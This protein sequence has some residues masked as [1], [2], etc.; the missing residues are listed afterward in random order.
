MFNIDTGPSLPK[1]IKNPNSSFDHVPKDDVIP[2]DNPTV[3]KAEVAS[4]KMSIKSKRSPSKINIANTTTVIIN[5]AKLQSMKAFILIKGV[6]SLLNTIVLLPLAKEMMDIIITYN[7][8]VLIPP[9]VD[10]GEAPISIKIKEKI[11]DE[12][13]KLAFKLKVENPAVRKLT[14]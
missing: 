11:K 5:I 8:V 6:I 14:E 3:P 2:K 7:V 4:Y 12:F 13:F 10:R 1:N 9:P